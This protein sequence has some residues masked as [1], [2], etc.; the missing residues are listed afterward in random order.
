MDR[1]QTQMP[2]REFPQGPKTS[3]SFRAFSQQHEPNRGTRFFDT[4]SQNDQTKCA[5]PEAL[6]DIRNTLA[7]EH[8][9]TRLGS[10]PSGGE[11]PRGSSLVCLCSNNRIVFQISPVS[12]CCHFL[13]STAAIASRNQISI[14]DQE[15]VRGAVHDAP[16]NATFRLNSGGKAIS[17]CPVISPNTD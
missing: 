16:E 6:M 17:G 2:Y 14:G 11:L 8:Y 15:S 9:G 5:R 3:P 4:F 1:L 7:Q 10:P 13:A 12:A